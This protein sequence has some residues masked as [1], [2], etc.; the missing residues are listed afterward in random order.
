M[1]I[2][3]RIMSERINH[4]SDTHLAPNF[5]ILNVGQVCREFTDVNVLNY[6]GE[7]NTVFLDFV[8]RRTMLE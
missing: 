2:M 3:V 6:L 4:I 1:R 7:A 8:T 5:F